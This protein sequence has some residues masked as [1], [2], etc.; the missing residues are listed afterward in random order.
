MHEKIKNDVA[1]LPMTSA[2]ADRRRAPR[3]R[4]DEP[5]STQLV[6]LETYTRGNQLIDRVTIA[7]DLFEAAEKAQHLADPESFPLMRTEDNWWNEF[8]AWVAYDYAT[9]V[10]GIEP[11]QES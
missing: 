6:S 2:V 3:I 8:R 5:G 1:V 10:M 4:I 11:V 9:T 7:M